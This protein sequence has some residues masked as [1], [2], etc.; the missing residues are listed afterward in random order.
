MCNLHSSTNR[1]PRINRIDESLSEAKLVNVEPRVTKLKQVEMQRKDAHEKIA[2]KR[3]EKK[4]QKLVKHRLEKEKQLALDVKKEKL[5]LIIPYPKE[6]GILKRA[7]PSIN[8]IWKYLKQ[9]KGV[10]NK[11]C[12][13]VTMENVLEKWTFYYS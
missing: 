1:K 5:K 7:L 3:E 6:I 10:S 9:V 13:E 2:K 11:D 12:A 8:Q 4:E